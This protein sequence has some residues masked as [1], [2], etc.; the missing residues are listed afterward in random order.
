MKFFAVFAALIAVAC[1]GKTWTLEDLSKHIDD[2]YTD[3]TLKLYLTEALDHMV[4]NLYNGNQ[5][6]YVTVEIPASSSVS[7]TLN[8]LSEILQSPYK[9]EALRPYYEATLDKIMQDLYSGKPEAVASV[10]LPAMEI[11]HYSLNELSEATQD[12]STSAEY[13][14][15]LDNA[16]D[17]FMDIL[18]AGEQMESMAIALPVASSETS[19][20]NPIV[21]AG[22]LVQI[23]VNVKQ[24]A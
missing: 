12:P 22:P 20:P 24:Q 10:V 17:K 4:E 11:Y 13:Q 18:Y 15:Y 2:P 9:D 5:I 7:M 6:E 21:P 3:P 16:L 23:I 14:P 8:Q 19:A 1:A